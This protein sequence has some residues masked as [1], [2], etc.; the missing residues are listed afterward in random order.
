[1]EGRS[2]A[3]DELDLADAEEPSESSDSRR[4][5]ALVAAVALA[6]ILL[7]AVIGLMVWLVGNPATA[8]ALRDAV[9]V[10]IA[11]ESVITGV[12]VIVLVVQVARLTALLQNEVRPLLEASNETLRTVRGTTTFLS[13]NMVRPVVRLSGAMSAV[14]RAI[15]LIGLGRVR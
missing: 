7:A 15:E 13:E 4:T 10:M 1:V 6:V 11:L 2:T 8:E 5:L 3:P 12:A 14:R 9:I